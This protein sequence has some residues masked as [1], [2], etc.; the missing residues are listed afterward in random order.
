[1]GHTV[2]QCAAHDERGNDDD[3]DEGEEQEARSLARP[4]LNSPPARP[5][6]TAME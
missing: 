4:R 6:E 5:A 1:M 3:D 2:V